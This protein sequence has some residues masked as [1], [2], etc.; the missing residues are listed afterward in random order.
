MN[1]I[2]NAFPLLS[3]I[4]CFVGAVL[5]SFSKRKVAFI[6]SITVCSLVILLTSFVLAFT[7]KTNESIIY[8]MGHFGPTEDGIRICNEIRVGPLEAFL[9]IFF[10]TIL[11]LVIISGKVFQDEDINHKKQNLYYVMMCLILV[12]NVSLLYTNDIF[13]GFVF[14]EVSTLASCGCLMVK[15]KGPTILSTVRYMIFNLVG[16]GL[17]LIGIVV[18]YDLTGYLSIENIATAV[19]KIAQIKELQIPLYISFGLVITGL[20]IKSGL[21]PFH[22]WMPDAYGGATPTSSSI[23]SGIVTKGYLFLL[24]KVIYRMFTIE[25]L[26]QTHILETLFVLGVLG[27]IVGSFNAINQKSIDRMT[28]FSSAAQI[29]Y[30][31]MGIGLSCYIGINNAKNLAFIAFVFHIL[32]HCVTKSLLFIS[33]GG[34]VKSAGGAKKFRN[35][36]GIGRVDK[37]SAVTYSVGA[38][39]M[40][41]FPLFAG[42]ISKYFFVSASLEITIPTWMK[43]FA[44]LALIISTVLNAIYF[45][46]T[47]LTIYLRK[48]KDNTF[49][50]EVK[51]KPTYVIGVLSLSAINIFL[52]VGSTLIVDIINKGFHLF[53]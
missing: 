25:V 10:A 22:F 3:I 12:S 18:L 43:V 7:L 32:T 29:G 9:A 5:S 19:T 34:L 1:D 20:S 42:F 38:L 23:L 45:V 30:I 21:F 44:I 40:I 53:V 6:I 48:E 16:S 4:V 31:F 13:T 41:G 35:L 27:M 8:T 49:V 33:T 2:I 47:M 51:Y 14:I 26:R 15:E 37:L 17:F 50:S 36:R 11:M 39:S 52:G 28:A 24:I 46:R